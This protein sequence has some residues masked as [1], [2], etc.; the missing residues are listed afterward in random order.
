VLAAASGTMMYQATFIVAIALQVMHL[1]AAHASAFVAGTGLAFIVVL[2]AGGGVATRLGLRRSYLIGVAL[3]SLALLIEGSAPTTA[4]LWPGV[5]LQGLGLGLLQIVTLTRIARIGTRFGQG[6]VS[7]VNLLIA[8]VGSLC[9]S[10]IGGL[11]GQ[12]I[13]LQNV[14]FLFFLFVPG[15]VMLAWWQTYA[16]T[17]PLTTAGAVTTK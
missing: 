16:T 15:F 12:W 1:D 8:P 13:G 11:L 5:L 17:A 3:V 2:F 6:K 10:A 4:W 9:G 7:G 14:F